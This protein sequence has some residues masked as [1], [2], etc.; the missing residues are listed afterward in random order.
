MRRPG[1]SGST[2]LD[3]PVA[4][5]S[6]PPRPRSRPAACAAPPSPSSWP[7]ATISGRRC[8]TCRNRGGQPVR[9]AA[10]SPGCASRTCVCPRPSPTSIPVRAS[11]S[12]AHAGWPACSG[13]PLIGT[14]VKPSVGFGPDETAALVRQLCEGGIDFIKDDELQSDGPHCPFDER[15]RAVMR[16]INAHA[17]RTGKNR[18]EG[19]V[20]LQP[21]RRP[22]PDAAAA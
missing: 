10:S 12:R 18:P 14:I 17:D 1:S 11:A 6:L 19:D 4:E 7:I 21:D 20:R 2:L 3:D 8:R 9:A 15:V 16:V 22:R 13:R 5:P